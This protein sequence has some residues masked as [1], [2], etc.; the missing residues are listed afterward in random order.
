M[1]DLTGG[2]AEL[3]PS[4]ASAT[5]TTTAPPTGPLRV[6][7]NGNDHDEQPPLEVDDA[8]VV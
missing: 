4:V 7:P 5:G 2:T 6:T 8:A 1:T 3:Q